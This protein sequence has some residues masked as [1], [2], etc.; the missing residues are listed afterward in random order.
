RSAAYRAADAADRR[1]AHRVLADA[2]DAQADPD[3]RAWHLARATSRPHEEVAAPLAQTAHPGP[4]PPGPAG[5]PPPL[6][7]PPPPP[8]S[9]RPAPGAGGAASA[10]A[11]GRLR[12]RSGRH[13]RGC[14]YPAYYR[15]R[16]TGR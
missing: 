10:R 16:R 1:R 7:P 4:A 13:L 14:P 6:Y 12:Q 2:T 8:P 11:G 15:P 9:A 5:P 3:R